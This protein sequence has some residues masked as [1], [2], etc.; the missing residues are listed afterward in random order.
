[1][2]KKSKIGLKKF[3]KMFP[4][5]ESARRQF[6]QW[7]WGYTKQCPYCDSVRISE[8][9]N[10]V[11]PYRCKD[12]RKRFS[13]RTNTVMACSNLPFQTWM[14][15]TFIATTSIKG[16]ASTKLA[17]ELDI[18]QKSAW[19]LSQRIRKAWEYD[20]DVLH[21]VVEI[22][23]SYFGGEERNKHNNKKIKSSRGTVGKVAV[24]GAKKSESNKIKAKVIESTDKASLQSFISDNFVVGSIVY[25][26]EHKSYTNIHDFHHETVI[27]STGDYV[28]GMVHINGVESFWALL[29]RGYHETHHY[30]SKKHLHRHVSEF[31]GRHGVR[32]HNSIDDMHT[33]ANGMFC[34]RL[35]YRELVNE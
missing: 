29:K 25:T 35:S 31:L 6:E 2:C 5:D 28:S 1:M 14:L 12:C 7:R 32:K 33:V 21:G 20:G 27:H 23:E 4:N 13:V 34:N 10:Q 19:H 17:S 3:F 8:P 9:K 16:I 26:D 30:M 18:T 15:A 22:G 11:M 24:V